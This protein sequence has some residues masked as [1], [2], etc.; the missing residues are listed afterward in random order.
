METQ[1]HPGFFDAKRIDFGKFWDLAI[2]LNDGAANPQAFGIDPPRFEVFR[3][4]TFVGDVA[5]GGA[6]NVVG[7]QV[8]PHGNG[9]HTECAGHIGASASDDYAQNC[10]P[11]SCLT[12]DQALTTFWFDA[13]LIT[14][15]ARLTRP[16]QPGQFWVARQDLEQALGKWGKRLPTALVVRSLPGLP[17]PRTRN[18]TGQNPPALEPAALE[19]L[20]L[21][22]VQHLL[23]DLPSVDPEQDGGLLLAHRGFW[24]PEGRCRRNATITELMFAGDEIQDGPYALNLMVPRWALD[25]APSRPVLYALLPD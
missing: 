14:V 1:S 12:L 7:V 19:W 8:N 24:F 22:G 15:P 23:T 21:G 25:A 2:P 17:D 11:G 9:T 16:E 3:A 18:Y 6:C 4:G 10:G 5:Q 20:A 13:L